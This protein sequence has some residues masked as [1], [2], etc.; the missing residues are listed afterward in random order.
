M[1]E[2]SAIEWTTHTFNP[3]WGCTKVGPGCDHCYAETF[4]R[5]V[6]GSHWGA[7]S[8]RRLVKDWSGPRKWNAAAEHTGE[9]PWVFCASM[10]D[11]FDNEAPPEWRNRLWSLV[12]ECR[13]LR[14]Q[15]VTKRIGNAPKMLP[16]DWAE[17]FGHCGLLA[18]IVNQEEADRDIPKLLTTPAAWRGLPVRG[19]QGRRGA[20]RGL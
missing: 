14:W 10:A 5:R 6:G 8:P 4:D 2:F 13:N 3:W 18:T 11:V 1:A 9:R 12:R 7:G 20:G 17:N 15:F 16:D 19:R